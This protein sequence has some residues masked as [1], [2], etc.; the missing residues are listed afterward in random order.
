MATIDLKY[1][2]L[3]TEIL[4]K[5][6]KIYDPKRD[7]NTI[8]IPSYELNLVGDLGIPI[9]TTKKIFTKSILAELEMFVKGITNISF[10]LDKKCNIW[11]KDAYAYYLRKCDEEEDGVKILFKYPFFI[12]AIKNKYSAKRMEPFLP[13]N[14]NLG[15]LGPIY[16]AQWNKNDQLLTCIHSLKLRKFDR[17][18]II[19]AWDSEDIKDMALPPC[20]WAFEFIQ[21]KDGFILKWHQRSVDTFLGL[22]FNITSYAILGIL[23]GA[24][25]ELPFYGLIGDLSNVHIYENHFEQVQEQLNNNAYY[26][27]NRNV[28]LKIPF[29]EQRLINQYR[30]GLMPLKTLLLNLSISNMEIMNYESYGPIKAEMIAPKQ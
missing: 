19:N 12:N 15:D 1:N 9:I 7:L 18:L 4:E 2:K 23:I 8:Q 25:A 29:H 14:Y 28:A 6:E 3:L 21:H 16:G 20:H 10:L 30:M 26:Y 17:R 27:S 13:K 24:I 5:G 22:P 11:N